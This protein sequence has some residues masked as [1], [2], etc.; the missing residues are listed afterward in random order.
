MFNTPLLE[1]RDFREQLETL[2]QRALAGAFTGNRW[3][4][5]LKY[6]TRDFAIKYGQQVQ[7]DRAKKAESLEDRL[8]QAVE[9]GLSSCRSSLEGP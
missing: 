4:E 2:I 8:S 5:S 7:L 1:I 9:G 3:W 6:R